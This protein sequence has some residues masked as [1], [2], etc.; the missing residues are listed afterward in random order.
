MV[1]DTRRDAGQRI[2]GPLQTVEKPLDEET[3]VSGFVHM[4]GE[5]NRQPLLLKNFNQAQTTGLTCRP[6][7][8]EGGRCRV[9]EKALKIQDEQSWLPEAFQRFAPAT[10]LQEA[11]C[12][13]LV[14]PPVESFL[15]M[16]VLGT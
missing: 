7:L 6:A 9:D 2:I 10:P 11:R 1:E 12:P 4:T 15:R 8:K 13:T 16:S 14:L 3:I 5:D